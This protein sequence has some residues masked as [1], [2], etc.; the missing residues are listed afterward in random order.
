MQLTAVW[1]WW[2]SLTWCLGI[3]YWL[4]RHNR[5][6]GRKKREK[7]RKKKKKKSKPDLSK[8]D[9]EIYAR[10]LLKILRLVKVRQLFLS[11]YLASKKKIP[12]LTDVSQ[13]SSSSGRA[14]ITL[15][16]ANLNTILLIYFIILLEGSTLK[17]TRP[18]RIISLILPPAEE[19]KLGGK[20]WMSLGCIGDGAPN[21]RV[22][23]KKKWNFHEGGRGRGNVESAN[24]ERGNVDRG[25]VERGKRVMRGSVFLR[26]A[27]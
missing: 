13:E 25:T 11:K 16:A 4:R 19:N 12:Q 5:R 2:W 10:Y 6:R 1:G 7:K 15:L 27:C 22:Y 20:T 26:S 3:Y 24:V 21:Q 8:F 18:V 23:R 14:Y 17:T 9:Y